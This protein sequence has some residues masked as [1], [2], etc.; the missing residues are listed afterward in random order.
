MGKA[1]RWLKSTLGAPEHATGLADV[2]GSSTTVLRDVAL[3]STAL[4][5]LVRQRSIVRITEPGS[6]ARGQQSYAT[7]PPNSAGDVGL[8]PALAN[9]PANNDA[10]EIWDPDGPHPDDFDRLADKALQEDC[11]YWRPMPFTNVR[12]GD[13]GDELSVSGSNIVDAL[14]APTSVNVWTGTTITPTLPELDFPEGYQRR[15][16]RGTATAG[17]AF[18]ESLPIDVNIDESDE[19]HVCAMARSM[20]SV[21]GNAGGDASIII[22][23]LTNS[24]SITPT[25]ELRWTRRGWQVIES[26]FRLPAGCNRIAFRL[27]VVTNTQVFDL[28]FLQAWPTEQ[29]AFHVP[30]RVGGK[31]QIGPLFERYG[32]TP[33]EFYPVPWDGSITRREQTGGGTMVFLEPSPAHTRLWYYEKTPFPRLTSATPAA[34]DDDNATWAAEPWISAALEYEVFHY[35]KA[36][37]KKEAPGRWDQDEAE[38]L[39]LL[40]AMQR[41]YGIEPLLTEDSPQPTWPANRRA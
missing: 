19:W 22:R 34:T 16:I 40:K 3:Y 14:T 39:T 31:R 25:T 36:R 9:A 20:A 37:D 38:A 7:G 29:R 21:A 1:K 17:N 12:G 11:W 28:A 8:S 33:N 5:Q 6:V 24:A 10:Y 4:D 13:V 18:L 30:D 27:Q 2:P 32:D 35:L 26:S 23:D 15:V 41:E